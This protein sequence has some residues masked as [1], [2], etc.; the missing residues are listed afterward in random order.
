MPRLDEA[1]GAEGAWPEHVLRLI[2]QME[3]GA[4]RGAKR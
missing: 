1:G 2:G 4:K 3:E